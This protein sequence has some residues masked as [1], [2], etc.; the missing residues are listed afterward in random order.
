M[1]GLGLCGLWSCSGFRVQGLV[2]GF[3]VQGL[4]LRF[5]VYGL[6]KILWLVVVLRLGALKLE[7][8]V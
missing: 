4:V 1:L 6:V 8:T 7:I 5:R 2:L 3:K